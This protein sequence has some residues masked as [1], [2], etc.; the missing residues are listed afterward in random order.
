MKITEIKKQTKNNGRFNIYLD[1]SYYCALN[2]ETIVKNGI[3][4]GLEIEQKTLDNYQLESEKTTALEKLVKYMGTRLR[5]EKQLKDYLKTKGYADATVNYC[6]EKLKEYNFI[7]DQ[8][9]IRCYIETNKN[10]KGKK[11]LE[12]E[13][14]QKGIKDNLLEEVLTEFETPEEVVENMALKYLKNKERTKDNF[15]KTYRY[16]ASKGFD[17]GDILSVIKRLFKED[18]CE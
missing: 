1:G 12:M 11:L 7:D 9:Y 13:L 5:T 2:A 6:M 15:Q 14:R 4:T 16:L 3:K 18:I 10:K 8:N 17:S